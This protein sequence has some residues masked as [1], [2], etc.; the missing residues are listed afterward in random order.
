MKENIVEEIRKFVEEECKKPSSKYGYEHYEFHFVLVHK[1]AKQLAE[2]LNADVEIVELSAW[3]H[4][5]GSIIC[6]RKN[7]H[8][9]GVKIAEEKLNELNYPKEKIE[10]VKHC[11]LSHRGSQNIKRE[12]VEAQILGDAD[13]MTHFDTIEGIFRAAFSFEN[14]NQSEGKKSTWNKLNNSWNKLSD[15]AKEIIKPKYEAAKLLF[16]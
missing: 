9:T 10:N 2:E 6:G 11:I 4:D 1:Y 7:H 15:S 3:L 12:S 16:G 8:I 5:I 13:A 14:Q